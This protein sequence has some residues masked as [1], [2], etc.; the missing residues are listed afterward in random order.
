MN[1][2]NNKNLISKDLIFNILLISVLLIGIGIR[3]YKLGSHNLWF[4]EDLSLHIAQSKN[5][6]SYTKPNPP[7]YFLL[8]S[9]WIKFMGI[10]EFALRLLSVF[11]GIGS[12]YLSYKIGKLFFD[13]SIGLMSALI[14]SISP[15][16][17]W[18]SQEARGYTLSVFLIM[19]TTYYF[20]LALKENKHCLWV[21]F[22]LLLSLSVYT[23]Y[24]SFLII[25]STGT[26]IIFLK[27]YRRLLKRWLLICFSV[28][29]LFSPWVF[30][31]LRDA[32]AVKSN[33]WLSKPSLQSLLVT[34]EN[35]NVGYN[36]AQGAHLASVFIYFPLLILGAFYAKKEK[37]VILLSFLFLPIL[38][39]FIISQWVPVYIDRQLILFSPFYYILIATGLMKIKKLQIRIIFLGSIFILSLSSLCNYYLDYLPSSDIHYLGVSIKKPFKPT[40]RY[41][42]EN[43]KK[44]DII[45]HTIAGIYNPFVTYWGPETIKQYYFII[46]YAADPYWREVLRRQYLDKKN[47]EVIDLTRDVESLNF[48]RIWLVTSSWLRDGPL[49]SNSS[50][51]TEWMKRHYVEVE[52]KELDG[53]FV[54]LY[55]HRN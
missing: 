42:K 39:T 53:I 25:I 24:F 6:F 4:D 18:Y 8:L 11:F 43:L 9:F 20:I 22:I 54:G 12:I 31:F 16:H 30:S 32:L 19:A 45:A 44:G 21:N 46:P 2:H 27:N 36:A 49:D 41:I 38:I 52:S 40:I 15:I 7:L 47:P 51:V 35:F 50:A 14:I 55:K 34:L 23:N 3:M 5:L 13:R 29:I 1:I 37:A 17:I 26:V 48:E 33:F 10:S 28:A